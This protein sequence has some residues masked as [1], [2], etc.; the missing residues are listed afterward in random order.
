MGMRPVPTARDRLP[1]F[2]QQFEYD[3]LEEAFS[4]WPS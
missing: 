1:A 3:S 2:L 4:S